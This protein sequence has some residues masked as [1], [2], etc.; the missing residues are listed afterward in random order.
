MEIIT[1]GGMTKWNRTKQSPSN[2]LVDDVFLLNRIV[3]GGGGGGG[4]GSGG[5][6]SDSGGMEIKSVMSS[7]SDNLQTH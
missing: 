4:S 5:G 3:H 2:L 6:R 1:D 7:Y